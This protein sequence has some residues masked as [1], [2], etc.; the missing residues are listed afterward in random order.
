[1]CVG[2]AKKKPITFWTQ[3]INLFIPWFID[4]WCWPNWY[5]WELTN[6]TVFNY[7]LHL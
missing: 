3:N 7:K 2:T 6:M 1:M 4:Q 5:R